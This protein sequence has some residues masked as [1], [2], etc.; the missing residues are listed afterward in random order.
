MFSKSCEYGI[1]A[2]L[3]IAYKSQQGKRVGIKEIAEGIDSPVAFTAKIMQQISKAKIVDSKKG[4]NGGFEMNED[5]RQKTHILD[6]VKVIDGTGL[7]ENCGLGLKACNDKN[8]C[9]V[10]DDFKCI[11]QDL[12]KLHSASSIEDLAKKLDEKAT[13]KL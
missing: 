7:Y 3:C 1:R 6:I 12:I 10:H 5:K 4:L 8:P 11:R 2:V 9:P 13:L